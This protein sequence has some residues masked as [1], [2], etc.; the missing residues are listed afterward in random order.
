MPFYCYKGKMALYL[1]VHKKYN[2]PYVGIVEG[3]RIEH[4]DL[5]QEERARM[6]IF[7]VDP[8]KDV[9]LR[10]LNSILRE[11]LNVY[12][13]EAVRKTRSPKKYLR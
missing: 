11:V 1:W 10:K 5:L 7:L 8:N 2:Q 3:K 12:K 9:P 4:P 13:M 6:K